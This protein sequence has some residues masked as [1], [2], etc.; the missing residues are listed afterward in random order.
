M[1]QSPFGSWPKDPKLRE[2]GTYQHLATANDLS[3]TM[4]YL[5]TVLGWAPEEIQVF[6]ANLRREFRS[7]KIH[8]YY[9][10]KIVWAQ[11]PE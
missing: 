4:N 8:A 5:G 6:A 11:K 7:P 9:L 2:I 1:P 3:G 10:Q